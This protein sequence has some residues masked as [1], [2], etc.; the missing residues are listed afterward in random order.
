MLVQQR[1]LRGRK[2][3]LGLVGLLINGTQGHTCTQIRRFPVTEGRGRSG[4]VH[5]TPRSNFIFL[6]YLPADEPL[7]D[8]LGRAE[9]WSM[10]PL[11]H[12]WFPPSPWV[13]ACGLQLCTGRRRIRK[14]SLPHPWAAISVSWKGHLSKTLNYLSSFLQ[15][16]GKY[17][18]VG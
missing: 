14:E 16:L 11:H 3:V 1:A 6:H 13:P 4:L 2:K 5:G 18:P 10:W 12:H 15:P 8:C 17:E 9:P 7:R